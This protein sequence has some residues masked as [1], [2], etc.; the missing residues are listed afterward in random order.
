MAYQRAAAIT[1]NIDMVQTALNSLTILG[2]AD[3]P[4]SQ[5]PALYQAATGA[6]QDLFGHGVPRGEHRAGAAGILQ[7][8]GQ[9]GDRPDHRYLVPPAGGFGRYPRTPES[10]AWS[11]PAVVNLVDE[12]TCTYGVYLPS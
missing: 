11:A 9:E 8:R 12:A 5:L 3:S 4:E 10:G 2:G 6:G 7:E 1:A